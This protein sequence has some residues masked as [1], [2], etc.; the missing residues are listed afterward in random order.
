MRLV[1]PEIVALLALG[2]VVVEEDAPAAVPAVAELHS[3]EAVHEPLAATM[4]VVPMNA[5]GAVAPVAER[6]LAA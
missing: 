2:A 4:P 6:A 5:H 3:L 1:E